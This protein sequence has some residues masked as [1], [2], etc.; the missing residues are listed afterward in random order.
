M[1][2]VNRE[3]FIS[4]QF[5]LIAIRLEEICV[6]VRRPLRVRSHRFMCI[7]LRS[8]KIGLE[9]SS[10]KSNPLTSSLTVFMSKSMNLN[11]YSVSKTSNNYYWN[12]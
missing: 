5:E 3:Q 4:F 7:V 8:L 6:L 10:N 9:K 2:T 11:S 1:T 12:R